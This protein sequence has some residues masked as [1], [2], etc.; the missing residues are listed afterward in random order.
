MSAV[1]SYATELALKQ[2][3]RFPRQKLVRKDTRR[4]WGQSDEDTIKKITTRYKIPRA[5][6]VQPDKPKTP[7]QMEKL[8]AI[9]NLNDRKKKSFLDLIV[10]PQGAP[11]LVPES[12]PRPELLPDVATQ[13]EGVEGGIPK[14][15]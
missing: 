13:F 6:V 14:L 4:K 7:A 1:E 2:G 9:K 3:V 8:D 10:K 11:V 12:D 5:Q 15:N